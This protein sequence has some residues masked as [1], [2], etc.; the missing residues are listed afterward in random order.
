MRHN[1]YPTSIVEGKTFIARGK[2]HSHHALMKGR[3][4]YCCENL[5]LLSHTIKIKRS[6]KIA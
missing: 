6:N 2:T 5:V 4:T 1:S 3:E